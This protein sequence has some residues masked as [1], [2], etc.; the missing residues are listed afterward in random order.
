[1]PV[2]SKLWSSQSLIALVTG[3]FLFS[4]APQQPIHER[5]SLLERVSIAIMAL[6]FVLLIKNVKRGPW[7]IPIPLILLLV[8]MAI[9]VSQMPV[10]FVVKDLFAYAIIV[11]YAVISVSYG[12]S[13]SV[14]YGAVLASLLLVL[15]TAFYAIFVPQ[16]A[17]E[18][19]NHLKGA[20][21]GEN[22]LG[23]SLMFFVPAIVGISFKAP[24]KTALFRTLFLVLAF[25]AIYLSTSKTSLLVFFGLLGAW[26]MFTIL[27]KNIKW[28]LAVLFVLLSGLIVVLSDWN[29][30]TA[31]LGK[32]ADLSGRVPLWQAYLEAISRKPLEGFGWHQRTTLDMPLGEFISNATGARQNN[33]HNDLLNWWAL[34]GVF[35]ALLALI[36]ILFLILNSL[37]HRLSL[38]AAPWVFVTG[39]VLFI[40]GLTEVSTMYPDG[41][42]ILSLALVSSVAITGK[43]DAPEM[44]VTQGA[45][46]II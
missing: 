19:S 8:V 45:L 41:W 34:T 11:L 10:F 40:G 28:G 43:S 12:G 27:K 38:F 9:S 1:M 14:I 22:S 31:F 29:F 15:T 44:K 42:A 23:I 39:I 32:S 17:F 26:G 3:V 7:I 18:A 36:S 33:A 37:R 35:G 2:V 5:F 6:L 20:F 46:A 16:S 25:S 13:K 4:L 24:W 30:F 21:Y